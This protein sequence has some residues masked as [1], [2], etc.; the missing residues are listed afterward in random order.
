MF[1]IKAEWRVLNLEQWIGQ[2]EID[3]VARKQILH[4]HYMKK[5]A[6]KSVINKN[7]AIS[8]DAKINILVA[9]LVIIMRN[10]S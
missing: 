10:V 6:S 8:Q 1:G 2:A 3:S 4:S 5:I 7:S 9:D